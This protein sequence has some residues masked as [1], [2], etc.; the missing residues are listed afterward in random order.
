[1]TRPASDLD[2]VPSMPASDPTLARL[3]DD[4]V[5]A[6]AALRAY[7]VRV[8]DEAGMVPLKTA[9][10]AWNITEAA[11]LMRVRRNPA[12]GLKKGGRWFVWRSALYR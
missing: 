6:D 10:A 7:L 5:C 12:L 4:A 1:V 9:A 3:V 8:S 11:A 2:K